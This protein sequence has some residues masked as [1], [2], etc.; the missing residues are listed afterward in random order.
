[1]I[2][3]EAGAM[4]TVRV[5]R[6][7]READDADEEVQARGGERRARPQQGAGEEDP[8][9]LE[10]Q[11]HVLVDGHV[12]LAELHG[13]HG[14]RDVGAEDEEER[15]ARDEDDIARPGWRALASDGRDEHVAEGPSLAGAPAARPARSRSWSPMVAGAHQAV[16]RAAAQSLD[17]RSCRRA[18]VELDDL[19]LEAMLARAPAGGRRRGR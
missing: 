8:E 3:A 15:A 10:R 9:G 12:E 11:R 1:M 4:D 16:R 2:V 18:R 6:E 5:G 19:D 13:R 17:R 7:D 14:E